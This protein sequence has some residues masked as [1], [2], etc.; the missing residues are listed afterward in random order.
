MRVKGW[1]GHREEA[2]GLQGGVSGFTFGK[3]PSERVA[4]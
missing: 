1:Q 4:L 2:A 3:V